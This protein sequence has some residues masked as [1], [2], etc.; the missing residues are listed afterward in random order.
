[1]LHTR[2]FVPWAASNSHPG[3]FWNS[4]VSW[5]DSGALHVGAQQFLD[6][7][8]LQRSSCAIGYYSTY[9]IH[10]H[11]LSSV[12]KVPVQRQLVTSLSLLLYCPSFHTHTHTHTHT[13]AACT[14]CT[15][16]TEYTVHH[17]QY[18]FWNSFL[19]LPSASSSCLHHC[20]ANRD[21]D[22]LSRRYARLLPVREKVSCCL[23]V[24]G[25]RIHF[26]S[27]AHLNRPLH[28]ESQPVF[29]RARPPIAVT[30]RAALTSKY[31]CW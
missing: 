24:M 13:H 19:F 8:W 15:V 4:V 30:A 16:H 7:K 11:Q 5:S 18:V 25:S 23:S 3:S 6:R 17:M 14:L 28:T 27:L 9:S 22:S 31:V 10:C 21:D 2:L 20:T 1:M 12:G 29:A 26:F